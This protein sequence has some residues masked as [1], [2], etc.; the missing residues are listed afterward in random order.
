L[1]LHCY[2]QNIWKLRDVETKKVKYKEKDKEVKKRCKADKQQWFDD[3]AKEAENAAN[4]GVSKRVFGI[5]KELSGHRIQRTHIKLANGKYAKTHNEEM[6]RWRY[7]FQE[8]LNYF[9]CA[10]QQKAAGVKTKQKQRLR[11]LLI[12]CSLC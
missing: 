12:R 9:F 1:K 8:V 2:R 11:R 3:K 5:V 6:K 7:H 4:T 10:H